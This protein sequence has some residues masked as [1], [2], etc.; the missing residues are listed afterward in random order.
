MAFSGSSGGGYIGSG[1]IAAAFNLNSAYTM[2]VWAKASAVPNNASYGV[3]GV[4]RG[5]LAFGDAHEQL[6]WHHANASFYRSATHRNS[7]GTYT[8]SQ[9]TAGN[10]STNVWTPMGQVWNGSSIAGYINGAADGSVGSLSAFSNGDWDTGLMIDMAVG[11][12]D[13]GQDFTTGHV[14]EFAIWNVALTAD[15]IAALGKGF[16]AS[17]IR[18]ASLVQYA[19]CVRGRQEHRLGRTMTL[20]GTEVISDHPRVFG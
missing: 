15:E 2:H 19:P 4:I 20:S 12:T 11:P 8:P 16:R 9:F 5:H 7:A 17:R 3:T 18:P 10:F 1:T 14:A 13:A 6:L